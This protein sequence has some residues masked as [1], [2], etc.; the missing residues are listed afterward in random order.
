MRRRVPFFLYLAAIVALAG[1]IAYLGWVRTW[2]SVHVPAMYPPFADMRAIQGA[3]ISVEHGFNPRVSNLGDP[4]RRPFNYPTL[5]IAIGKTLNL[6]NNKRFILIC[7]ALVACFAG[8]CAFLIFRFPSFGLLASLVSTATLLGIERGNIDLLVFCLLLPAALW[9]PKR[10]SPM[11]LLLATLLKLY[12]VFALSALFIRRQFRLFAASLAV[13]VAIFGY[14]WDQLAELRSTTPVYCLISYG[15]PSVT[16]CFAVFRLPT[17]LLVMTLAEFGYA[18]LV[19]AYYFSK[20]DAAKPRQETE[21]NLMLVGAAI[22]IGTFL[23]VSNWDYRLIFLILCIP[24]LQTKPFP[25][26]R[27]LIVVILVAM[28]ETLV[29][30]WLRRPGLIVVGLAK[31]AIF[32]VLGAYLL[33]LA[34]AALASLHAKPNPV[35]T[36]SAP[37]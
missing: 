24:F 32:S 30:Y 20:S 26:A 6:T 16:A 1:S 10:W 29:T 8:I 19:L 23:V 31:L 4:W 37:N 21:F 9:I 22:Y 12:P 2:A 11:P 3:V 18:M 17:W 5:W 13:A 14:L 33:A 27:A 35:A 25:L 7:T 36:G 34:W 28:N 15:V